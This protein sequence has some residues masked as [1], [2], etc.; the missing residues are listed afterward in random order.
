MEKDKNNK[1]LSALWDARW[2]RYRGAME[3]IAEALVGLE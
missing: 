1:V 2:P 3:K